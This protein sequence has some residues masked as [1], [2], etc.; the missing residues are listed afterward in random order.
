M[1]YVI[2]ISIFTMLRREK[3][4]GKGRDQNTRHHKSKENKQKDFMQQL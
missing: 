4:G 3:Y 2:K 1:Y